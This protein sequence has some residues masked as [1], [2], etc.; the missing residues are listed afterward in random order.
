MIAQLDPAYVRARPWKCWSRL[1]AYT[2]FEGRPLTTKGQWINPLVL[3]AHRAWAKL[4]LSSVKP[5]PVFILG[6]GRSGTTILGKILGL[7]AEL[8]FLNEPKALWHAALGDDDLVGSYSE[9]TGRYRMTA[10]DC[11]ARNAHAL[12]R[13][14]AAFAALSRSK[15]ILDKYPELLFRTEFLDATFPNNRKL[16]ITRNCWDA[17]GSITHWSAR[18]S[19][20]GPK[21]LDDWWGRDDRKWIA[22][23]DQILRPDPYFS[24][25]AAILNHLTRHEDRA[26]LEWV[27][28]MQEALRLRDTGAKSLLMLRY[29]DLVRDPATTLQSAMRFCDL[30]LDHKVLHYAACVLRPA[31]PRA[32]P[33]LHP[34]ITPLVTQTMVQLGY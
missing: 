21:G 22:L 17:I 12:R 13:S 10:K 15:R 23:R 8:G 18:H 32:R 11:T 27:A 29:E 24:G 34:Q 14:Y 16:V 30:P 28:T 26:A 4:P 33:R 7:H 20:S 9:V 31:E 19:D 25:I 1:L 3:S 5:D 6:L 2:V